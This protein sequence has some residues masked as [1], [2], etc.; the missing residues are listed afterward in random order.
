MVPT[1]PTK[2]LISIH[3]L[4]EESDQADRIDSIPTPISI[5]ALHEES[6]R[7]SIRTITTRKNFNPRS[8]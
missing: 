7:I 5:H 2:M 4:H 3:A 8:P 6:D 1:I